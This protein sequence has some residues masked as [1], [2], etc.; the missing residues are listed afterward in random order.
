MEAGIVGSLVEFI[1]VAIAMACVCLNFRILISFRYP[2]R[3][4]L[5]GERF[6]TDYTAVEEN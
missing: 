5:K 3:Y 2:L 6:A 1:A 4:L